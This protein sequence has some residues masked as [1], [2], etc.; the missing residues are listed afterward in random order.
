MK[1]MK[2]TKILFY[3]FIFFIFLYLIHLFI[4]YL[5][6]ETFANSV[7]Y[8]D[9]S[10]QD[11]KDANETRNKRTERCNAYFNKNSFCQWNQNEN[12]CVCKYQKDS[13][14]YG[15]PSPP[16]CC[17]KQC[18]LLSQEQ[19]TGQTSEDKP[20]TYYCNVGGVCLP[21]LAET[22]ENRISANNCGT[23]SLNNQLLLPFNTKEECE[24]STDVC[25]YYNQIEWTETERRTKCLKDVRCGY[26]I[27]GNNNGKCISGTASGP[28]DLQKYYY[29]EPS[30]VRDGFEYYYGNHA[31]ALNISQLPK[32]KP[33]KN[34]I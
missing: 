22:R 17:D 7:F 25:D 18:G 8:I 26:C 34:V 29:C 5:T 24:K 15:F 19:C 32:P 28:N 20:L 2:P 9:N 4:N 31:Q 3:L 10:L 30:R 12:K 27:S 33:N 1:S 21:R 13:V 6:I 11:Y 23:D 14:K 16:P